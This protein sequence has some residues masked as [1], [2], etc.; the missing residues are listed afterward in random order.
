MK[1]D[2]QFFASGGEEPTEQE[3]ENTEENL[4]PEGEPQ[5]EPTQKDE[6]FIPKTRFDEVNSK[7]KEALERLDS[8]DKEK[9]TKSK[10]AEA[11]ELEAK[12]QAGEFESLYTDVK[13]KLDESTT[14]LTAKSQRV[15]AL[16]AVVMEL[17]D[18]KLK[19]IDKNFHDLIPEGMS[20]EQK[21]SWISKAESKG[22]F[23]NSKTETPIGGSTNPPTPARA[24]ES[25][26]P[27]EMFKMAF[28]KK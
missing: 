21:L 2:L 11:A 19:G 13:S 6:K 1:L 18:S 14:N 26:S 28:S 25:L 12:K 24:L 10:E 20:V 5:E 9:E 4:N 23:G 7:L 27:S 3:I 8:L 22:M 15:E 16:E 17:L